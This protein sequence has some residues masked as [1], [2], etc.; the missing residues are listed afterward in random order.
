MGRDLLL[1]VITIEVCDGL[2]CSICSPTHGGV[3]PVEVT[4]SQL[5]IEL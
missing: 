3:V 4:F 2:F 5:G 1:H